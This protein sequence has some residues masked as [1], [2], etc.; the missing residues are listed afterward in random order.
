MSTGESEFFVGGGSIFGCFGW[1]GWGEEGERGGGGAVFVNSRVFG[2]FFWC[3]VHK[4]QLD[5]R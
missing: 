4:I 2:F 1:G 5:K 3:G